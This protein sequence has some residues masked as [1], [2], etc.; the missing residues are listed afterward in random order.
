MGSKSKAATSRKKKT[1]VAE[2]DLL[3][4][5]A[6]SMGTLGG[7]LGTK[8]RIMHS[9]MEVDTA[10]MFSVSS[11]IDWA[12][13]EVECARQFNFDLPDDL[14]LAVHLLEQAIE[15]ILGV[16]QSL[17]LLFDEESGVY[18]CLN[19]EKQPKQ[20]T[21]ELTRISDHFLQDLMGTEEVLHTHLIFHG[22]LVGIV[23]VA[24][25][26][27]G[28]AFNVQDEILLEVMAPY[29]ATK[30]LRFK[31]L[32]QSLVLPY[33]QSI[34]LDV[35]TCLVGAV[36][37]QSILHAVL[38]ACYNR[39]HFDIGQFIAWNPQ[40]GEGDVLYENLH[41]VFENYS[42]VGLSDKRKHIKEFASLMSLMASGV[43]K[44]PFLQIRGR[45]LG[46]KTLAEVFSVKGAESALILP[47]R[48]LASQSIQGALVL[49]K[50][51]DELLPKEDIEVAQQISLLTSQALSRSQVLEKALAIATVD[52]LTGLLNRRGF[53]ERFEAE[54]ERARRHLTHLS[55]ALIDVDFFKKLNDT[56]GH[57]NGDVVLRT[58]GEMLNKNLR[59]S[60]VVSR[61]GGEEF[62]VL[63]PDTTVKDAADLIDR[64][65]HNIE[66]MTVT[67]INGETLRVTISAGV[68]YVDMS[69][70]LQREAREIISQSLA[71]A[72]EELYQ[73]KHQG[74]NQVC[75]ANS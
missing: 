37:E 10:S 27:N 75:V 53:Y 55:V 36:D 21:R 9:L 60:D 30:A 2:I 56:Y 16:R 4:R 25:K 74:R 19:D 14:V 61:F 23:A 26:D 64:L 63:L 70:G 73:A 33:K 62:A 51:H 29:L 5:F 58:L 18:T 68:S 46:D 67:G 7:T 45:Q 42:H 35:S 24:N 12:L 38:D 6:A 47:V 8:E 65:R 57:L 69:S 28:Q 1:E 15:D 3:T 71:Q 41:G 48:E 32:K 13:K 34:L 44:D 31:S 11:N 20:P 22:D 54:I 66:T 72:D 39:L 40:T 49:I 43:R 52:E 17:I 50:T 59:K